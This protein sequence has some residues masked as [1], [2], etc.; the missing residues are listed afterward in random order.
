M[1]IINKY[2]H[3]HTTARNEV[4]TCKGIAI[5]FGSM[6]LVYAFICAFICK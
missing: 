6:G 3:R 1:R 2:N 4:R 5:L